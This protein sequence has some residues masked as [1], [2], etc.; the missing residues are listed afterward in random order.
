MRNL[1]R[2]HYWLCAA[3]PPWTSGGTSFS[4]QLAA[5]S[6]LLAGSKFRGCRFISAAAEARPGDASEVMAAE[7][8]ACSGPSSPTSPA[9]PARATPSSWV[10][11]F[12]CF[13]T[14]PRL[15]HVWTRIALLRRGP[16]VPRWWRCS[17]LRSHPSAAAVGRTD[18]RGHRVILAR[19]DRFS[20]ADD[21][22]RSRSSTG[23]A[24]HDYPEGVTAIAFWSWTTDE[25]G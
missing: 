3:G 25:S 24:A 19:P 9:R 10:D 12:C 16:C 1:L 4:G 7:Y 2:P 8:R 20:S 17:T 13:T 6:R 15:P 18:P 23:S 11:G 14:A 22:A 5:S 21:A